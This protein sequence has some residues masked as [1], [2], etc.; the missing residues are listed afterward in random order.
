MLTETASVPGSALYFAG[1]GLLLVLIPLLVALVFGIYRRT[2]PTVRG[3]WFWT[4]VILRS[5]VFFLLIALLAE[6][7]LE[8]WNKRVRNPHLLVLIDTSPSMSVAAGDSTRLQQVQAYLLG[9]AWRS[10]ADKLDVEA[11]AFSHE[12]YQVDIDTVY[13]LQTGGLATDIGGTI[14][15]IARETGGLAGFQGVL[16]L[17]DGAHNLGRDPVKALANSKV[18]IYALNVGSRDLPVDIQF[19]DAQVVS[20]GYVGKELVIRA[21][22]R[23]QGYS[24]ER[25]VVHLY[26]GQRELDQQQLDLQLGDQ[27]VQFTTLPSVPGPH[28]YRLRID[29]LPG[30]LTRDNNET[31]VFA[32]VL[33]ERIRVLIVASRPSSDL[34]FLQRGLAADSTLNVEAVVKKDAQVAYSGVWDYTAL[35][36]SDVLVLLGYDEAMWRGKAIERV[37][38]QVRGGMGLLFIADSDE[39]AG[40]QSALSID[41]LLPLVRKAAPFVEQKTLLRVGSQ[42]T[43]HPIIR[44]HSDKEGDSWAALPPLMGYFPSA[45]LR[46]GALAL[47]ESSEGIPIVV[48]GLYGMG[49]TVAALSHSFWRLDLLSSGIA[50][51]PQTVRQLWRN[52]IRWLATR[53]PVGRVRVSTERAVYRAGATVQFTAQVFD[54]LLQPQEGCAVTVMLNAGEKISLRD[55]GDGFYRGE[56]RG[57]PAGEYSY[58]VAAESD[59]V[60]I[61]REGG[62]F[63]VEQHSVE[64]TDVRADGVLLGQLARDSGGLARDIS[65]GNQLLRDWKLKQTLVEERWDLRLWGS[66]EPLM[67][68]AVLL[69]IEWM[70]RKRLGMI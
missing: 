59:G 27:Q 25:V 38:A 65:E 51:S 54:E 20:E 60:P 9:E 50:G 11:W 52:A 14:E 12:A 18:P 49:K 24:G 70:V 19:V 1:S 46:P 28:R 66:W 32:R 36:D 31:L 61:G 55:T 40:W 15:Q 34:S 2:Y 6:P 67:F 29:P 62:D 39:Q 48:S 3:G 63:V 44:S 47:V 45:Q 7:I 10:H 64:W 37:R 69:A 42:G 26:D 16:L 22:V 56:Y 17:T 57:A 5:G 8:F 43:N 21:T 30:E 35:R 33:E 41:E 23:N 58:E 13:A 68:I 53:T 4:L